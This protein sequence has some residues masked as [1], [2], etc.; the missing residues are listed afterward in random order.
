MQD[1]GKMPPVAERLASFVT[2]TSYT[3]LPKYVISKVKEQL[4]YHIGLALWARDGNTEAASMLRTVE[5]MAVGPDNSK[6]ASKVIGS[7]KNFLLNASDAAFANSVLMR[8]KWKDDVVWPSGIHAGILVYPAGLAYGDIRSSSGQD[9]LTSCAL[10]YEI[11]GKLGGEGKAWSARFPRRDTMI[12]GAFASMTTAG[13]LLRLDPEKMAAGFGFA[14]NLCSGVPEEGQMDH[15]YGL[16]ARNACYAAEMVDMGAVPYWPR[17]IEGDVGLYESFFGVVPDQLNEWVE[18]LGS[19][20]EILRAEQKR[21]YGTGQ[22]AVAIEAMIDLTRKHNIS[23]E[24]VKQVDVYLPFGDENKA[25]QSILAYQGPF[26]SL[27]DATSSLPYALSLV[28]IKGVVQAEFYTDQ[29]FAENIV[30][31]LPSQIQLHFRPEDA[32]RSPRYC[33]LNVLLKNGQVLQSEKEGLSYAFPKEDWQAWLENLDPGLLG[34][35]RLSQICEMVADL[36][37]MKSI[38]ELLRLLTTTS[39]T[40]EANG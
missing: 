3:D 19:D 35:S 33:R 18:N 6:A 26:L 12:F 40:G 24:A 5:M 4:I 31:K 21:H 11:V 27:T 23:A 17:T 25:R 15:F 38:S 37:N 1:T 29:A 2:A 22:N 8:A 10:G 7:D 20:W 36:E 9:F 14:A 13:Y 16:I 28:L 32:H 39:K 30:G 34:P